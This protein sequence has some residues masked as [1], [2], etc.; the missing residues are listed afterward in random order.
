[1]NQNATSAGRPNLFLQ[2][3]CSLPITTNLSTKTLKLMNGPQRAAFGIVKAQQQS[4]SASSSGVTPEIISV[5]HELADAAAAVTTPY[6]RTAVPVD[7]K[8]DASPVTIADRQA[9][10]AMR[11]VINSRFPSH[12]IFGEEQGYTPGANN[13]DNSDNLNG[14]YMWVIDPIDGTKSFITG[15]PLFGT[16]IALVHNGRPVL[17]IIDQPILKERWLGI[18]GTPTTLNN[19]P[20]STRVCPEVSS[21]YMYATTPHMFTGASELAFNRLRDQVRIPLY[22]CDCYAYGLLAAGH[23]DLVAEAD[24]K[25]YDY[26]ALIPVIQGAGG[27]ITDWNGKELCWNSEEAAQGVAPPGEVLAAGDSTC[28]KK[29]LEL[30]AW[31]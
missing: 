10:I 27:V 3:S 31:K 18:S 4:T 23:C 8:T 9:E 12:A 11:A 1:L 14:E 13:K 19:T 20:I 30:L 5:A 2:T 28:H 17:G 16:L 25:P 6:F 24:L 29:A 7:I 22:G 15:K 26:M 21:A